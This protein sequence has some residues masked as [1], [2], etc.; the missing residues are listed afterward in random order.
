LTD[1]KREKFRGALTLGDSAGAY[2][3]N[4]YETIVKQQP[5]VSTT[6]CIGAIGDRLWE[7]TPDC[8]KTAYWELCDRLGDRFRTI[9]I[10]SDEPHI[11]WEL[12]RPA[13][14]KDGT[15]QGQSFLGI[16]RVVGRWLNKGAAE[17]PQRIK[18]LRNFVVAPKR[19]G[20]PLPSAQ[21]EAKWLENNIRAKRLPGTKENVITFL[22]HGEA[23]VLHF[24]CHGRASNDAN[25]AEIELE[26]GS[27]AALELSSREIRQGLP[28]KCHPVIFINAC[29]SGRTGMTLGGIGGLAS[30]FVGASCSAVIGT[31]WSVDDRDAFDAVQVFYGRCSKT[32]EGLSIADVIREVRKKFLE[33]GKDTFLAY[34]F[35]GDPNATLSL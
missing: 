34:T 13:R 26:N 31:L 12:M 23:D 1:L 19:R 33:E 27:L 5:G 16:E 22:Q 24:S 17:P 29:E 4:L 2:L 7:I 14:E 3:Y 25:L 11:P 8:F 35:F 15:F 18:A 10:Y 30:A 32:E 6:N 21:R 9:Q 28:A 20:R